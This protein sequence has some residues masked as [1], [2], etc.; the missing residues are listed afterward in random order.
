MIWCNVMISLYWKSG[1]FHWNS[2]T[3]KAEKR[4]N[5]V[6]VGVV[7][8]CFCDVAEQKQ[9]GICLRKIKSNFDF[10]VAFALLFRFNFE[11]FLLTNNIIL[12]LHP[13][14]RD[15]TLI[16]ERFEKKVYSGSWWP[17]FFFFFLI[18]VDLIYKKRNQNLVEACKNNCLEMM[19]QTFRHGRNEHICFLFILCANR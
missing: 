7:I 15:Y 11:V 1:R 17:I 5:F 6:A 2:E 16:F 13:C 12:V 19:D 10:C 4:T 3:I 14:A 9:N 8:T 18:Y